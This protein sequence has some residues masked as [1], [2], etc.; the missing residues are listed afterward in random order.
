M[1]WLEQAPRVDTAVSFGRPWAHGDLDAVGVPGI[2]LADAALA[3]EARPLAYWPDGTVKW[4]AHAVVVPA[5]TDAAA[6]EP[7][8]APDVAPA[9]S[10]APAPAKPS[11]LLA[12]SDGRTIRVDTGAF[13]V[14]I[15]AGSRTA[16]AALTGPFT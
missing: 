2:R 14:A 13:T 9:A 12:A 15:P 10:P 16:G 4:T 5:G 7:Q 8:L 6:L 3:H 1:K 11:R